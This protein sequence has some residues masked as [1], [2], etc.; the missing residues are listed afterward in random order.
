MGCESLLPC[1]TTIE[2]SITDSGKYL[3][4]NLPNPMNVQH[5]RYIE[6]Q[7]CFALVFSLGRPW[8]KFGLVWFGL[9]WFGLVWFGLVWFGLV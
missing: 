7:V 6:K 9:V 4:K 2:M 8:L 3:Q 5:L 1:L